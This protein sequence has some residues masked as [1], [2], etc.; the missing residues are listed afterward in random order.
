MRLS[1]LRY[2][3][4][5]IGIVFHDP[6]ERR[7]IRSGAPRIH[8]LPATAASHWICHAIGHRERVSPRTM[9]VLVPLETFA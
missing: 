9:L 8:Q 2:G 1:Q 5:R 6:E 4:C 3:L 7:V